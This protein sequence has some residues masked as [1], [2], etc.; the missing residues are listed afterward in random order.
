MTVPELPAVHHITVQGRDY[1]AN[2]EA[3]WWDCV[4]GDGTWELGVTDHGEVIPAG[5]VDR[6]VQLPE[7]GYVVRGSL[8]WQADGKSTGI[9]A[10]ITADNARKNTQAHMV[11]VAQLLAVARAIDAEQVKPPTARERL[12]AAPLVSLN[13]AQQIPTDAVLVSSADL[14]A[15]LGEQP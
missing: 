8:C 3:G 11:F 6:L 1:L 4:G 15:A 9:S 12:L 10:A 7:V 5:P 2:Y 14:R 13:Y